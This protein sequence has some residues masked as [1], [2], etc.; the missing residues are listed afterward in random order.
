MEIKEK[1]IGDTTNTDEEARPLLEQFIDHIKKSNISKLVKPLLIERL[2][3]EEVDNYTTPNESRMANQ[4]NSTSG[5]TSDQNEGHTDEGFK[6]RKKIDIFEGSPETARQ[7]IN[8]YMFDSTLNGWDDKTKA[9]RF[10]L[11]LKGSALNWY[12]IAIDDTPIKENITEIKKQF[13][14][15]FL[16]HSSKT[17]KRIGSKTAERGRASI[18]LYSRHAISM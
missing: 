11:F 5:D 7:W 3:E 1:E 4:N 17:V 6:V 16:P 18:Q 14:K 8:T 2:Q 15:V 10:P 9:I 12:K 13:E